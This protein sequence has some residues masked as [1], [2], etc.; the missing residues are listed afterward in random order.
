MA[1]LFPDIGVGDVY[2]PMT[3]AQILSFTASGAIT[4]GKAVYLS[5][6]LTVS[7]CDATVRDPIGI[8]LKTVADGEECPV[9]VK[10]VVKVTSGGAITRGK[11][12]CAESGAGADGDIVE[13]VDQ[14]VNEGGTNTYTIPYAQK[15]GIALQSFAAAGDT[16]L[17]LVE[18]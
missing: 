4:K 5:G 14:T 2:T 18:K 8:A 3:E 15:L 10:G 11:A 17:I 9:L 1:D 7:Q 16:G 12:V 6:D 13:L